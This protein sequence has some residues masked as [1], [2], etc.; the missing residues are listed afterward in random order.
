MCNQDTLRVELLRCSKVAGKVMSDSSS[1]NA[2][3]ITTYFFWAFVK[4][5][6]SMF[7]TA[8]DAVNAWFAGMVEKFMGFVNFDEGI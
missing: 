2:L 1:T 3:G 8:I 6:V 4:N 7:W 5:P